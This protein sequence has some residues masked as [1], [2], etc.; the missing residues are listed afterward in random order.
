MTAYVIIHGRT[1]C[2]RLLLAM[3]VGGMALSACGT[4][5]KYPTRDGGV[6]GA[7]VQQ[8]GPRYPVAPPLAPP[9]DS[10]APKA[11][12]TTP[13]QIQDL[14]PIGASARVTMAAPPAPGQVARPAAPPAEVSAPVSSPPV[15]AVAT[16]PTPV[17]VQDVV[18]AA[19]ENLFDVAERTRT[20]V[21][22]LIELNGLQPPYA[23]QTGARLKAPPALEYQIAPADTLF[24]VARR[25]SIDPRSLATLNDMTLETQLRQGRR[26]SL[27]ALARDQGAAA[28]ATG[29]TPEGMAEASRLA[30]TPRTAPVTPPIASSQTARREPLPPPIVSPPSASDAAPTDQEVTAAGRGKFLWPVRGDILSTYGPKGP[31]QR[32]DGLNISAKVGDTVKAA[33]AGE[34]VFA[35]ELPGFGNLVLLKHDGGW[36]TAYAHLSK[37]GVRMRDTVSQGQVVGQ[38]GQSG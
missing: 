20:P 28:G 27:P 38:V 13:V 34:V 22:A 23:L 4:T 31:G 29:P 3:A 8:A 25:F 35:G 5:P 17:A 6:A 15:P 2:R 14:P 24:G 10:D 33:A 21:R 16:T 12:P 18:V 9:V 19:G 1:R 7:G 30:A 26:L 37:I 11:K 32:N 36:V